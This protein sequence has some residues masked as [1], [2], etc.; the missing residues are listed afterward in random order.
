MPA[1]STAEDAYQSKEEGSNIS[2]LSDVAQHPERPPQK[3]CFYV[4]N[5][6]VLEI[7]FPV[8]MYDATYM[9]CHDEKGGLLQIIQIFEICTRITMQGQRGN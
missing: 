9:S 5:R 8:I 3:V 4:G 2:D 1:L 7:F 6:S